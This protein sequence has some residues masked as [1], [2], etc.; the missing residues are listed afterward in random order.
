MKSGDNLYFYSFSDI[1]TDVEKLFE[2]D[3]QAGMYVCL[4]WIG[5]TADEIKFAKVCDYNPAMRM[6]HTEERVIYIQDDEVAEKLK[7]RCENVPPYSMELMVADCA[8]AAAKAEELGVSPAFVYKMKYF[9]EKQQSAISGEPEDFIRKKE[10][11][12]YIGESEEE[13][14]AQFINYQKNVKA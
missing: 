1:S 7:K 10:C 2:A 14:E 5:L 9:K 8:K 12:K 3:K 13:L 6:L 4:S 11:L